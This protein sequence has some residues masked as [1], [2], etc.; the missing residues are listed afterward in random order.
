MRSIVLCALLALASCGGSPNTVGHNSDAKN[1]VID[2]AQCRSKTVPGS[3]AYL[4]CRSRLAK[5]RQNARQSTTEAPRVTC[6]TT[7]VAGQLYTF[8]Q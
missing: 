5:K 8:C 3:D 4:A 2:D 7:S 6:K 1:A